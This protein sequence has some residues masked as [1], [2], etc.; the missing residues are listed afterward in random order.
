MPS[1]PKSSG[2][3]HTARCLAAA[4]LAALAL[5][6]SAQAL[7]DPPSSNRQIYL[8][9]GADRAERLVERAR[10]ERQVML[11]STLTVADGR[12]LGAAFERKYG[13]PI[14]ATDVHWFAA[15]TKSMGASSFRGC[16]SAARRCKMA[17]EAT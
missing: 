15:V 7:R 10:K 12:A 1:A 3:Q 2:L 16:S 4:A 8:Y 17:T 6:A 5:I 9:Q 14:E 11:Y 13:I